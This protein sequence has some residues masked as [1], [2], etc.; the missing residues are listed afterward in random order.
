MFVVVVPVVRNFR[1]DAMALA[2]GLSFCS[3][4]CISVPTSSATN[5]SL[6]RICLCSSPMS[7]SIAGG[8]RGGDSC[9]AV[10]ADE[11]NGNML[12]FSS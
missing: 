12:V 7:S 6:A 9:G 4:T 5:R 2:S 3:A 8:F 10:G 11:A 1:R